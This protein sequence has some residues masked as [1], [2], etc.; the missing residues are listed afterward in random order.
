MMLKEGM[1]RLVSFLLDGGGN[2]PYHRDGA[3]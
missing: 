2:G 1:M 3:H